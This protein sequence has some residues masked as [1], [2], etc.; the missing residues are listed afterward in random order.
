MAY[1][2]HYGEKL[3]EAPETQFVL[4]KWGW[5]QILVNRP[6]YCGK[7]LTVLP[8]GNACSIHFHKLKHETFHVLEGS[9][10]LELLGIVGDPAHPTGYR[11]DRELDRL[12]LCKGQALS[13]PPLMA[14]RFWTVDIP[15]VFLE[16][17][18]HDDPND[19]YRF[20]DSGPAPDWRGGGFHSLEMSSPLEGA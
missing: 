18:S 2:L 5:E 13:L 16:T 12:I 10:F 17:S 1:K 15:A 7:I 4:K 6:E 11:V 14:H 9:I 20:V 3:A 19:S 8:N